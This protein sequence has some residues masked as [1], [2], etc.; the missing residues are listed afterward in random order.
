MMV[1]CLSPLSVELWTTEV[2]PEIDRASQLSRE[3]SRSGCV[4]G[5]SLEC[6]R[7]AGMVCSTET[8][9]SVCGTFLLDWQKNDGVSSAHFLG[10]LWPQTN[11]RPRS[12]LRRMVLLMFRNSEGRVAPV[13]ARLR[14]YPSHGPV[15][16]RFPS[17]SEP[18]R[19]AGRPTSALLLRQ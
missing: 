1:R 12:P 15:L 14:C 13:A 16:V 4:S 9:P 8:F 10:R 5:T 11:N 17:S 19:S 7:R 6:T 2:P 3:L 18:S